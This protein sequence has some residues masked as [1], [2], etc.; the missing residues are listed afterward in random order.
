[1]HRHD[2]GERHE[3]VHHG[4]DRLLDLPGVAGAA[5]D[6]DALIEVEDDEG[7]AAGAVHLGHALEAG[8]AQDGE[9]R[10]VAAQLVMGVGGDEHVPGEHAVQAYSVMMRTGILNAGSAP[11]KQSC[12]NRSRPCRKPCMRASS[13]PNLSGL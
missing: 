5:D 12:T 9:L 11:T 8:S 13:S 2:A 4:E 10:H 7:L 1:V 3:V 6:A